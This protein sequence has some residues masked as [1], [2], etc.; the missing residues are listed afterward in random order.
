MCYIRKLQIRLLDLPSHSYRCWAACSSLITTTPCLHVLCH[1][2]G[3]RLNCCIGP[4]QQPY[5][6][7][8]C[9]WQTMFI[10]LVG[11]KKISRALNA[12]EKHGKETIFLWN[13][14]YMRI[15]M[16]E[17]LEIQRSSAICFSGAGFQQEPMNINLTNCNIPRPYALPLCRRSW[18]RQNNTESLR[19][20]PSLP[21]IGTSLLWVFPNKGGKKSVL[22]MWPYTYSPSVLWCSK[23]HQALILLGHVTPSSWCHCCHRSCMAS[24]VSLQTFVLYFREPCKAMQ[25]A[26]RS[27][28]WTLP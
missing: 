3:D 19:A 28:F 20:L 16:S 18:W 10:K 21:N 7:Q 26:E 14:Y 27:F 22:W 4:Q 23:I 2:A 1:T 24:F 11:C 12:L 5:F 9:I 6:R 17:Q 15:S 13:W 25:T 8:S